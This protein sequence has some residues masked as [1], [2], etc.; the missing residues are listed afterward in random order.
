VKEVKIP[1][2]GTVIHP[3][4]DE[5][6]DHH[7]KLLTARMEFVTEYCR[8][9]GWPLPE[10]PGFETKISIE[11]VLEVRAQPGWQDPL[12]EGESADLSVVLSPD[13]ATVIP[14]GRN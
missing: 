7:Q 9:K 14:K 6:A 3:G 2:V 8:K 1:G 4:T 13:G 11:Q 5:E 10:D 12:G